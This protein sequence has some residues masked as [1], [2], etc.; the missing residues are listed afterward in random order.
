MGRNTA[1]DLAENVIDIRQSIAIQLRSNHYPPVPLSM[2][3]PCIEAIHAVSEGNTH[4][5]INLPK[6]VS[7][8][9]YPTAPAY[10]IVEAHHLEPWCDFHSYDDE[11]DI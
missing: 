7:W 5:Q 8:R 10:T 9:G 3:E 2:V 11:Q 4:R 1:Q 6:G